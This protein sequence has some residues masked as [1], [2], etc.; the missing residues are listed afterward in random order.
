MTSQTSQRILVVAAHP[1]DEALGCGGMMARH[2][3]EGADVAVLFLAD[4]EM[5]RTEAQSSLIGSRREAARRAAAELGATSVTCSEFPDNRLDT[6]A[7]LDIT[8]AI[9][10]VIGAHKP[11]ILYTHHAGDVNVDHRIPHRAVMT[12]CRALPGHPVRAIRCFEVLS[13]TE[14]ATAGFGPPFRPTLFCD[15]AT[16]MPTKLA[17]LRCYDGEMRPF[18]HSRS[19]EAVEALAKYRGASGGML[20][21]EGFVIARELL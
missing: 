19:Y 13:S 15:I 3:A 14:W 7:I 4:G 20:A 1:D 18:P 17:A 2:A 12:A 9:E 8:Q 10:A 11:S 6:V 21:A 5:A 16:Y